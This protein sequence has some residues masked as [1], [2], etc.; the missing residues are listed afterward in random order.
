MGTFAGTG[1]NSSAKPQGSRRASSPTLFMVREMMSDFATMGYSKWKLNDDVELRIDK[2]AAG[3][4]M[5][6]VA[7]LNPGK[8]TIEGLMEITRPF[9]AGRTHNSIKNNHD[10]TH[11]VNLK[12]F[13]EEEDRE[14]AARKAKT[15]PVIDNRIGEN[16]GKPKKTSVES[17]AKSESKPKTP[18]IRR[19]GQIAVGDYSVS[20]YMVQEMISDAVERHHVPWTVDGV[21]QVE[22]ERLNGNQYQLRIAALEG[23]EL[24]TEVTRD[25]ASHFGKFMPTSE[26]A[27]ETVLRGSLR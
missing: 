24:S 22:L 3:D 26:S 12:D 6:T 18:E 14:I 19:L 16:F 9:F 25:L 23:N 17:P 1:K 10:G 27:E 5:L 4:P 11:E 8:L 13:Y 15:A 20:S 2:N 7:E 21:M